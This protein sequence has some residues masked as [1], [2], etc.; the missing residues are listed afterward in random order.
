[1]RYIFDKLK[2]DWEKLAHD[3]IK[4]KSPLAKMKCEVCG[5]RNWS[6]SDNIT[7]MKN[8]DDD[9]SQPYVNLFCDNCY[10]T[11]SFA[12]KLMDLFDEEKEYLEANVNDKY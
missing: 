10:N 9:T 5:K 2:N 3:W 1:M 4:S 7:L 8:Y 12:A 6:M 11:K